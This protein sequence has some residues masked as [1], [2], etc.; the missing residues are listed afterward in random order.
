MHHLEGKKNI[1]NIA[2]RNQRAQL[3]GTLSVGNT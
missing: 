2:F 1:E 3:A